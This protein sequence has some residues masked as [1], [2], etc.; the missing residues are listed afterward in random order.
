MTTPTPALDHSVIAALSAMTTATISTI[1]FKN[2]LHNTWMRGPKPL[3][4]GQDRRVGRAFT[5][6]FIPARDDL[7]TAAAWSSPRSTRIAV[8]AMPEGSVV[9]ADAMGITDAGIFGD[10]LCERMV[11]RG[12]AAL[13]TDGVVRDAAGVNATGLPVWCQ[14]TAS[15]AAVVSM[16]F[17]NWQEPIG[18]GGVAVFPGDIVVADDDGAI[19]IPDAFLSA[20]LAAGPEQERLE[21]WILNEVR[22]GAALPGLYPPNAEAMARYA[23]ALSAKKVAE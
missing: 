17:A 15:P 11:R 14:G 3:R 4:A 19:L 12:V 23:A 18:C 10:I 8:E 9:V 21:A 20:L 7:S 2:G 13:I 16:T 5:L 6:R 1:L 22:N